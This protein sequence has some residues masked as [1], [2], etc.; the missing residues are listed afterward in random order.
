MRYLLWIICTAF[1][2]LLAAQQGTFTIKGKIEG[3]QSPSV[4]Y[5]AYKKEGKNRIDSSLVRQG[6]FEI[7]GA[8]EEPFHA[9]IVVDHQGVGLY[10]L[11]TKTRLDMV[12]LYIEQGTLTIT[13]KDSLVRATLTGSSL[14]AAY[15][16][17]R[18]L[19]KPVEDSMQALNTVKPGPDVS[20]KATFNDSIGKIQDAL[21]KRREWIAELYIR[22][23]PHEYTSLIALRD[24]LTGNYPDPD[25]LEGLLDSL[26]EDVK[27]TITGREIRTML[28][29]IRRIKVGTEAP[30]F[31][32]KDVTGKLIRLSDYRGS[33]VLIDFWAS[34]CGPC[35]SS[36]PSLVKLHDRYKSKNFVILGVSLDK[37]DGREDW[38]KAIQEDKLAWA[39]VS[40]LKGWENEVAKLY[41]VRSIPQNVLV[42]PRGIIVAAKLQNEELQRFL[43]KLYADNK[44]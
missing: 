39:Q 2:V 20:N 14:A 28:H 42:D 27:Q 40:D 19:E 24:Y 13:G 16:A 41:G 22:N 12:K 34:W 18:A 7:T 10:N 23:H 5:L 3:L 11:N 26:N 35:R 43:D 9:S 21:R 8:M 17:F 44:R 31:V 32:Q 4:V 29:N 36:H 33:Y 37:P 25:K 6:S 1:P 30:D 38:L 15:L